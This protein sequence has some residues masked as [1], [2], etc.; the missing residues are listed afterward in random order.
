[1]INK[2]LIVI[3]GATA[4]GKTSLSIKVAK[5]FDAEIVNFDSIYFYN[6]L[7]IGSAKPTIEE[8]QGIEH[9]LINIRSVK[10]PLN[11]ADF[12]RQAIPLVNK[13][14]KTGKPVVLV[15]G[16]GFYLQALLNGMFESITTSEDVLKKS[17]QLYSDL[18]I[19]AFRDLLKK[20]DPKSFETLHENDHYRNR[21]AVEHFWQ[22]GEKFSQ[23]KEKMKELLKDSPVI[24]NKWNVIHV[25]LKIPREDHNKIIE[26][27][28]KIM[29]ENG[30][31]DEA[32]ELISNFSSD[33]KPLQSIGYKEIIGFIKGEFS[34]LD[35]CLER[36]VISTRQLAKAQRTWFKKVEK[37]SFN[38]LEN[39]EKIIPF[40][41]NEIR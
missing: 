13:I 41:K 15:G 40:I 32:K 26:N 20:E 31:L 37:Q 34:S 6:E 23:Q 38:P 36:I 35:E 11:A 39:S 25:H 21:R 5:E 29:L 3:S 4:T 33:L 12:V 2:N 18:G 9:H 17:D 22:T 24:Q 30:L 16:S 10:D 28:A 27:R 1:M 19:Q 14:Q 7:N 8:M